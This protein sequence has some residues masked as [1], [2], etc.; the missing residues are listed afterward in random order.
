MSVI[1]LTVLALRNWF[2][3]HVPSPSLSSRNFFQLPGLVQAPAL[4]E[5]LVGDRRPCPPLGGP[6]P[7]V[8]SVDQIVLVHL[9]EV[10]AIGRGDRVLPVRAVAVAVV[11][12]LDAVDV[13]RRLP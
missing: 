1:S 10:F 3:S 2:R 4:G 13:G 8:S 7:C 6:A 11:A 5:R 9:V 12:V